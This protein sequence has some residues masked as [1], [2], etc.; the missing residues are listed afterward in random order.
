MI[1]PMII[2]NISL[3][4]SMVMMSKPFVL[5][6]HNLCSCD[7]LLF[8]LVVNDDDRGDSRDDGCGR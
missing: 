7:V 2:L 8:M 6:A 1:Y 5:R 4:V 3:E